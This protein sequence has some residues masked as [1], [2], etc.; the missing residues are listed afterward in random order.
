MRVAVIYHSETGTTAQLAQQVVQGAE[1]V[2]GASALLL[3]IKGADIHH[4]KFS[5]AALLGSVTAADAI[6]FGSPTYMGSVSAEFKSFADAT[7]DI[8]S[9]QA[10][11]GRVCSGFTMGAN[12]SGDQL[13]AI[14]YMNILSNQHGMLWTGVD[15]PGGS[16]PQGRN[17]LGAQNGLI[18]N[19]YTNK[20][21]PL[22]LAT[23]NYLG[24]RVATLALKI[25]DK[26]C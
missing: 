13:S 15:I 9:R 23:A 7:S 25:N 5:N 19:T 20:V 12:P 1:S 2:T 17:R 6:I 26:P 18:A 22:D 10:W 8:W 21:D 3:E 4:G 11:S 24:A 16:D 14:Q